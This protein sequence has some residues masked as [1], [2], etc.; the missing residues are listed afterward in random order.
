MREANRELDAIAWCAEQ[1]LRCCSRRIELISSV[2]GG[3]R[4]PPASKE[5]RPSS[6]CWQFCANSRELNSVAR[7]YVI[8]FFATPRRHVKGLVTC[9]DV[10]RHGSLPRPTPNPCPCKPNDQP[11]KGLSEAED[12][13]SSSPTGS[14]HG[15]LHL[16][17]NLPILPLPLRPPLL[18][19]CFSQG[20]GSSHLTRFDSFSSHRPRHEGATR[21]ECSLNPGP[22]ETSLEQACSKLLILLSSVPF[23]LQLSRIDSVQLRARAGS[24]IG[25]GSLRPLR[26][27]RRLLDR[28]WLRLR[29]HCSRLRDRL[30]GSCRRR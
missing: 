27:R 13:V 1:T 29:H 16:L 25:G 24:H 28:S 20:L 18:G 9:P 5:L 17:L 2:S 30:R 21:G 26:E 19:R 15:V 3:V 4:R 14:G 11:H 10:R 22:Q 7:S 23:L 6:A 8:Q 12:F